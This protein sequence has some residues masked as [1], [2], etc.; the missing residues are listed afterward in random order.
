MTTVVKKDP[1]NKWFLVIDW[2][3]WIEGMLEQIG[4]GTI[5]I[6]GSQWFLETGLT[7][8][9]ATPLADDGLHKTFLYG[10]GG[11]DGTTYNVLNRI[12]YN[13][14]ELSPTDFT[15]DRTI[16]VKIQNK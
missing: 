10:S 11:V 13:P 2:S 7:K 15:E 6:T 4:A 5:D 1:D 3:E 14:S 9:P 16:K 12:T 8:E